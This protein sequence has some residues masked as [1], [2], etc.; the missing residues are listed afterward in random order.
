LSLKFHFS[1]SFPPPSFSLN[2]VF[3]LEFYS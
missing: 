1:V 3:L 2:L